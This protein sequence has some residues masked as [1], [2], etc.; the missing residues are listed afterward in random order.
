MFFGSTSEFQALLKQVPASATA[1]VIRM[2]KMH[3]LDQSGLYAIED[4][5]VE[6][7]KNNIE[8]LLVAIP[9]QP[10]YMMERIG[11]IPNL[12]KKDVIFDT[13]F[14]SLHWIKQNVKNIE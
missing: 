13:Y 1:V 8:V 12:I 3:Y 6:L 9:K 5:L 7:R 11:I 10:K 4:A 14:D 2:D